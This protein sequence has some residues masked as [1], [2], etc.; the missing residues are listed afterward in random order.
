MIGPAKRVADLFC[1]V[2]TFSLPAARMAQVS[3]FDSQADAIAALNQAARHASGIKPVKALVRDLFRAPLTPE[4]LTQF[5][6]VIIDPPRAGA[7]AQM[8]HLASSPI[9][10]IA[11]VS[12]DPGTFARDARILI[13]GGF[14]LKSVEIIDQFVWSTHIE[15][16]AYFTRPAKTRKGSING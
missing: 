8:R 16:I 10:T 7:D 12:C 4:E 14:E 11:A 13:D 5:D 3:A 9:A 6:A 2:G 1:G 15:L